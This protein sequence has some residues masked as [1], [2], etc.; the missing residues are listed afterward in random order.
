MSQRPRASIADAPS[1]Q[2]GFDAFYRGA[3]PRV[4]AALAYT[5]GDEDLATE[6]ADEAMARAFARWAT[7]A[8]MDNPAGWVYRVGLNWARSALRRRT[9]RPRHTPDQRDRIEGPA[10]ADVDLRAALLGLDLDLRTVVVCRHLW[11]WSVAETAAA[12][13]LRPGT[14]KSRL[15]RALGMLAEQLGGDRAAELRKRGAR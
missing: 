1:T 13:G 6:A 14:V 12:L 10:V 4:A 7:V 5:V 9:R 3:Y 2:D 8:A 11:D 15:H